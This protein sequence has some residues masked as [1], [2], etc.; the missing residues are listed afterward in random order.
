MRV[1]N[2]VGRGDPA[3]VRRAGLTGIGLALVV[4]TLSFAA[5]LGAPHWIAGCYTRDPAVLA[6]AATLLQIAGVFQ[7]SD[8]LQVSANG[9]LRGLRDTRVPMLVTG[10]AYWGVGLPCGLFLAFGRDLRAPGMWMGLIAGLSV[11]ATLLTRRFVSL[12]RRP[13][14]W[15]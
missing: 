8:G 5:M 10:F 15:R 2:A 1:S 4:Q 6:G 13:A 11:A 9:A 3:G 7:F 14:A 12:S